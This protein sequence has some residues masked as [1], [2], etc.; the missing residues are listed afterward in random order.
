[1]KV[2]SPRWAFREK[3]DPDCTEKVLARYG[4]RPTLIV[5][6]GAKK[7]IVIQVNASRG[8]HRPLSLSLSPSCSDGRIDPTVCLQTRSLVS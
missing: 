1:M 3:R 4:N 6:V 8:F 2:M 5:E 7:A